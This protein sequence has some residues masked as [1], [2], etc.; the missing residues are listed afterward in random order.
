MLTLACGTPGYV[1]PDIMNQQWYGTK[2]DVFSAGCILY[3]MLIGREV[4]S[5]NLN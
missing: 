5:G 4:F 3:Q 1:A 2:A